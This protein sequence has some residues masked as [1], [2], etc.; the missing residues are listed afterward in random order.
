MSDP[1]E[2]KD[3]K[4]LTQKELDQLG[5]KGRPRRHFRVMGLFLL[6]CAVL[7]TTVFFVGL[8]VSVDYLID[9]VRDFLKVFNS[10][11]DK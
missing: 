9:V 10:T 7:Y 5:L 11:Y 8:W 2:I 6:A 4:V 3:V 1:L